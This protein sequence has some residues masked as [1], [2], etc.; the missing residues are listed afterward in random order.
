[1]LALSNLEVESFIAEELERNPLLEAAR[2]DAAPGE[3]A[4]PFE[5]L[6]EDFQGD[7][8]LEVEPTTVDE[9]IIIGDGREDAPLDV[10]FN[11]EDFHQDSPADSILGLDG[12][13]GMEGL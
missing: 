2:E 1:L 5:A 8:Q 10:D 11:S 13:L 7:D 9:L 12:A 4:P 6:D 3:E